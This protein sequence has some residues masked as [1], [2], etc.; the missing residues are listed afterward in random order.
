[1]SDDTILDD[2]IRGETSRAGFANTERRR[3]PDQPTGDVAERTGHEPIRDHDVREHRGDDGR[4]TPKKPRPSS[5]S[6]A[7]A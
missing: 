2:E 6:D 3:N 4:R 7:K 5:T 1:M